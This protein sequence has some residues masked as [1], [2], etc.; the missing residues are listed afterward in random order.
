MGRRE[1]NRPRARARL[2]GNA[3][4]GARQRESGRILDGKWESAFSLLRAG[5]P[6]S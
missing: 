5:A 3:V 1:S 4:W 6:T 2:N